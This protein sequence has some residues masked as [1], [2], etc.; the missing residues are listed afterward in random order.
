MRGGREGGRNRGG[1]S[2][3]RFRNLRG[4]CGG[5][6]GRGLPSCFLWGLTFRSSVNGVNSFRRVE[7]VL[8]SKI[9]LEM[10]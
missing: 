5:Q 8:V 7:D 6:L 1:G 10:L 2:Y 9:K 3:F 4:L